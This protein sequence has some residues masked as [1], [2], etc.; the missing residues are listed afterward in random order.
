MTVEVKLTAAAGEYMETAVVQAWLKQ[1]GQWIAA[2]DPLVTVETAKANVELP[3]PASGILHQILVPTGREVP[4][5]TVLAL[6]A[7]EGDRPESAASPWGTAARGDPGVAASTPESTPAREIIGRRNPA[8]FVRATPRARAVARELGVALSE[9]AAATGSTVITEHDVTHAAAR[10]PAAPAPRPSSVPHTIERPSG[11]RRAGAEHLARTLQVPQFSLSVTFDATRLEAARAE[12]KETA[13]ASG[14]PPPKMTEFVVKAVAL[15]LRRVP[16]VNAQWDDGR[17]LVFEEINVGVA[18]ATEQGLVVPVIKGADHRGLWDLAAEV[19]R[20][21]ARAAAFQLTPD[22]L[23][24]GTFTVSNL[25]MFG[26]ARFTALINP[27]QA[28]ILAVSAVET[29]VVWADGG[30]SPRRLGDL[31]LTADHR[32]VDGMDGAIFLNL[33]KTTLQDPAGLL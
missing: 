3:A 10:R 26:I 18:V 13:I 28:G 5:G 27:P 29:H 24:G 7:A 8:Q 19:A 4:V 21:R 30:P 12:L 15:A 17:I 25:G 31:T 9:V 14:A 22:D 2:G 1:E 11:Y 33:V 23:Q 6:I 20:L 32:V 16:R